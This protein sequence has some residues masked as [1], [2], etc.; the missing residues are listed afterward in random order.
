MEVKNPQAA[1]LSNYEVLSLINDVKSA[2]VP[3]TQEATQLATILYE[4]SHYLQELPCNEQDESKINDMMNLLKDFK[5]PLT[6]LEKLMICNNPPESV[7]QF[8]L[9]V[10]DLEEKLDESEIVAWLEKIDNIMK[11]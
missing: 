4:T 5:P 10:K 3:T 6:K 9:I 7:L 8:S 11:S 1:I 2:N